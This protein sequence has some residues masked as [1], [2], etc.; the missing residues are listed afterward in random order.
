MLKRDVPSFLYRL[1]IAYYE[2]GTLSDRATGK[3]THEYYKTDGVTEAKRAAIREAIPNV[4]FMG[5]STMYAP[6]IRRTLICIPVGHIP[7]AKRGVK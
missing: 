5:A 4:G 3:R 1:G 6:E 2:T 7:K